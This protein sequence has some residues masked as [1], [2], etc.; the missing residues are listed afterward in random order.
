M[1]AP[2]YQSGGVTLYHGDCLEILPD[3]PKVDAV[4]TDPPYGMD[5]NTETN[6]FTGGTVVRGTSLYDR[7]PVVND[8]RPFDPTPW[9]EFDR[10]VLWG[11]HHFMQALP[12]GSVLVWI[13]RNDPAFGTFLSDA[14]LAW[15]K[16][17]HGV[18]CRRDQSTYASG[19]EHRFHPCQKPVGILSWCMDKCKAPEAGIILDPFMGSGTTGVAC[20]RSGRQFI[21]IEIEERYCEIAAKRIA[22]EQ[23]QGR[24]EFGK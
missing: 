14:D 12:T 20:V 3:L 22:L 19:P 8:D 18:Y 13:K 16:G 15:M 17:G 11:M 24:M 21:G 1:K 23:S 5:W 7:P 10:V 9:L 4:I 2:Y 6:R